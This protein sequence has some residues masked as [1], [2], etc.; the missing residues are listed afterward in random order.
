[1]AELDKT[2]KIEIAVK[3]PEKKKKAEVAV[4]PPPNPLSQQT[5]DR[6]AM[7]QYQDASSAMLPTSKMLQVMQSFAQHCVQT[8]QMPKTIDSAAK[9]IM[10]FQAGRE[11][12]IPPIKSINS[13]YFVN[14]RLTMFGAVVIER[15]RMWAKIQYDISSDTEAKIT[16]TRKD[17]G[18]HLTSHVTKKELQ[19]RKQWKDVHNAHPETML[20]Y[21]AVGRIVRHIV[22]EAVGAM[23]VEGDSYINEFVPEEEPRGRVGKT[24]LVQHTVVDTE[25]PTV[26]EIVKKYD[27]DTLVKRANELGI[28]LPEKP[29][30]GQIAALLVEK[31]REQTDIQVDEKE[32]TKE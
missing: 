28:E 24:E 5:Q 32:E 27:L 14:N 30:K 20:L 25:V 22:P 8:G 19:D 9:A 2:E 29:T 15:I 31:L 21:K 12:G 6:L 23:A 3:K 11:L 26:P 10:V 17:D 1:M 7:E 16:I 13:F 18:T 4:V